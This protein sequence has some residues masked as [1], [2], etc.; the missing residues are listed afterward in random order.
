MSAYRRH[1]ILATLVDSGVMKRTEIISYL[2]FFINQRQYQS[3]YERAIAKWEDDKEFI[4]EYGIGT[5]A[6]FGVNAIY[7]RY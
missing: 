5:Y 2:D 3:K 6:K 7:R 1:K 4:S